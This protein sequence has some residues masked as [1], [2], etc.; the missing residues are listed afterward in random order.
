MAKKSFYQTVKARVK[1][2]AKKH[3][4]AKKKAIKKHITKKTNQAKKYVLKKI[5]QPSISGIQK[6]IDNQKLKTLSDLEKMYGLLSIQKLKAPLKSE[7]NK[8]HKEILSVKKQI[9]NI[10]YNF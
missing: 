3:I 9:K 5:G 7:R 2:K 1:A 4:N 6:N 10:K 8:I